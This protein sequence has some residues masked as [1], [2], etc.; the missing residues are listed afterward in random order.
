MEKK[1]TIHDIAREAG[2][3]SCCVSWVLSNHPRSKVVS[4]KTR[5]RILSLSKRMGYLRN[6]MASAIRTGQVNTI[7][8]I[9]DFA[10]IQSFHSS[11]QILTGIIMEST[12]RRYSVKIYDENELDVSFRQIAENRIEKVISLSGGATIRERTA[13]L[14][15]KFGLNLVYCYEHGHRGFPAVNTDNVT[16]TAEAV[17]YIAEHGHSRIGLICGPHLSYHA[18]ERHAGYLRGMEE[19]GLKI[20]PRW[21]SCS[22]KTEDAVGAMLALPKKL[23]PTAFVTLSD[24]VAAQAQR[25]AWERGLR[26]PE[27]FSVVGI[28]NTEVS[29]SAM[30]PITSFREALPESGRLLRN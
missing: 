14:A 1:V 26:I 6:S 27:D 4:E 13:E 8:L 21:V 7:A 10:K 23:R 17:H 15:E 2:V 19:C 25:F 9:V 12:A 16:M 28:G 24:T 11:S 5:Q 3:S 20:D 18:K 22:G 30:V 29:R